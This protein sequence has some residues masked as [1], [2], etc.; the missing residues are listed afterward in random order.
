MEEVNRS[1]TPH[2]KIIPMYMKST[3]IS[4]MKERNEQLWEILDKEYHNVV[5][6]SRKSPEVGENFL[7]NFR[8]LCYFGLRINEANAIIANCIHM[9]NYKVLGDAI[10]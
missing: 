4:F 1:R 10:L 6:L 2:N 8:N 9:K 3:S 7:K 5:Q